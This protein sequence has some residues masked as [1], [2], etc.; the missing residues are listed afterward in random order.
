MSIRVLTAA[1]ARA[2]LAR[3]PEI[4]PDVI[5]SYG[6]FLE[7][8]AH[9][10]VVAL[11]HATGEIKVIDATLY[12]ERGVRIDPESAL[13]WSQVRES[14]YRVIDPFQITYKV[15]REFTEALDSLENVYQA[16][17]G[18]KGLMWLAIAGLGVWLVVKLK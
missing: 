6:L 16:I 5:P 4:T 9:D 7:E 11:V 18:V 8:Q 14:L 12:D 13:W 2:F 3:H 10:Y 17:G 15:G 1:E